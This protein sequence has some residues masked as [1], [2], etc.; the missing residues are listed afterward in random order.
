VKDTPLR[1]IALAISSGNPGSVLVRAKRAAAMAMLLMLSARTAVAQYSYDPSAADE[2]GKPGNLYFGAARDDG[3]QFV[4]GVTVL[5][6]TEQ[7]TFVLVTNALGRFRAKLP[8][9]TLPANVRASCSKPGYQVLKV[10]RR[11][12]PRQG[13]SPVQVDCLLRRQVPR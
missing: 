10:T 1:P 7:T 3:G 6:E 8:L 4:E 12:P 9:G 5:L 2:L 13:S 11:L